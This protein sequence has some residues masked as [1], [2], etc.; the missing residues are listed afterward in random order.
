MNEI[1]GDV[2]KIKQNTYLKHILEEN[3]ILENMF[4]KY[5]IIQNDNYF[6]FGL[7][8]ILLSKMYLEEYFKKS[9]K[10]KKNEK[11]ADFCSG[12]GI[13]GLYSFFNISKYIFNKNNETELNKIDLEEIPIVDF[14][15]KQQYFYNLNLKNININNNEW[16]K[17]LGMDNNIINLN[18][19]LN[20]YNIDLKDTEYLKDNFKEKYT[21]ILINPPYMA[22]GKGLKTI[23]NEKDIA[24]I[25][26]SDFLEKIFK[27]I[28][29]TLKDKGELF[30]VS[31]IENLSTIIYNAKINKLE[32]KVLQ[33]VSANPNVKSTLFLAKFVKN[34]KPFLKMLPQKYINN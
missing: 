21:T 9:N 2:G 14:F 24:K 10:L 16:N 5:N 6:K 8:S 19:Y 25:A 22:N 27:S 15:E 31:K 32:L 20:V 13:I 1:K 26:D 11:I 4:E 12:T 3:E 18:K 29:I 33:F 7:D 34:G 23:N 28:F 17:C 30:L